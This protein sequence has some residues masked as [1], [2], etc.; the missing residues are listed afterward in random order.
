MKYHD[1]LITITLCRGEIA[2]ALGARGL[3]VRNWPQFI[4]ASKGVIT[5]ET[6]SRDDGHTGV[7]AIA[8]TLVDLLWDHYNGTE[9]N[10]LAHKPDSGPNECWPSGKL[11]F[12]GRSNTERTDAG[13][14]R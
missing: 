6:I 4:E 14:I 2:A 13:G 5:E 9:G 7:S 12:D 8:D 10:G 1:K 3:M 11:W